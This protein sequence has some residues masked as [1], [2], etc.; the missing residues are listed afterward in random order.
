MSYEQRSVAGSGVNRICI[1]WS[2]RNRRDRCTVTVIGKVC[3]T[4]PI[5]PTLR[6][7]IVLV[8]VVTSRIKQILVARIKH[9]CANEG[10]VFAIRCT[11]RDVVG[12]TGPTI[13]GL[14]NREVVD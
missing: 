11:R 3:T 4:E 7:I 5:L 14:E 10:Q 6:G 12:L 13:C 1:G 9:N 2:N 8:Q